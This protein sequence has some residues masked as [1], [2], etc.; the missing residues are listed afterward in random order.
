MMGRGTACNMRS[1]YSNKYRCV[2]LQ[3]VGYAWIYPCIHFSFTSSLK[4]LLGLLNPA[5]D[6]TVILW[7]IS[8]GW[9]YKFKDIRLRL[10]VLWY[11]WHD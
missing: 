9:I 4:R 5:A 10:Q 2:T 7:K 6:G 11:K 3:L 1:N 8:Q